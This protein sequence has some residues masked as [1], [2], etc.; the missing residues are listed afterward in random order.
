M[1]KEALATSHDECEASNDCA[2][3]NAIDGAEQEFKEVEVACGLGALSSPTPLLFVLVTGMHIGYR[4]R[5]LE[6]KGP[7]KKETVH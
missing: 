7:S 2:L 5:Q 3:A 4:L 6:E 1:V